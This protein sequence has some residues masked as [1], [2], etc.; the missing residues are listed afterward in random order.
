MVITDPFRL[1]D[2]LCQK[3]RHVQQEHARFCNK[4]GDPVSLQLKYDQQRVR[5][6]GHDLLRAVEVTV[7]LTTMRRMRR[8]ATRR[9]A[10]I[11]EQEV[12]FG[13]IPLM[14]RTGPLS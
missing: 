6:A 1:G 7:R 8:Q 11:K 10:N 5:R 9:F 3:V 2:V 12:F 13:D 4:C 14:T